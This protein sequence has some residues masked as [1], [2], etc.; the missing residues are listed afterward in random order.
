MICAE[1]PETVWIKGAR[2]VGVKSR[3]FLGSGKGSFAL[4]TGVCGEHHQS[5]ILPEKERV[6]RIMPHVTT[7][8]GDTNAY[9]ALSA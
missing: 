7:G 5:Q 2:A 6:E 9:M 1:K 8:G 4:C 3:Q